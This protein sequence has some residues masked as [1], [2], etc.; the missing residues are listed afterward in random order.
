METED[1]ER[2]YEYLND[3]KSILEDEGEDTLELIDLM[4]KIESRI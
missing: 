2:I 1:L 4:E 3:Y